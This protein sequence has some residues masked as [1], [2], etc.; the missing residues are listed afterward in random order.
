MDYLLSNAHIVLPNAIMRNG[1]LSIEA[2]RI[3]GIG[4]EADC[5]HGEAT[6][7][8]DLQG[9]F[10][11]PGIVDLHCDMIERM[12]QPRPGVHIP[13]GV[14]LH[15]TDRLLLGCGVT[16]EFHSLSL[17]DDEFGV[18]NDRFVGSFLERLSREEHC[19]ARHFVHARVEVSSV[20]GVQALATMVGHPCLRL[21]SVM[22]HSPGQGQYADERAFRNYIVQT[23][24]RSDAEIDLILERKRIAV[25]YIPAHIAQVLAVAQTHNIPVASHDDDTPAKAHFWA[26]RGLRI[27]EFPTTL[28]AAQAAHEAGLAVGMGAPNVLRGQSSGG[29]LNA[30]TALA[31][32]VV[33]WL[34]ADYYPAALLPAVFLLAEEGLMDLAAAVALISHNPAQAVGMAHELGSITLGHAADLIVV[35]RSPDPIVRQVFVAGRL[36]MR[37]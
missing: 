24:G 5:P 23:T 33:D 15:A 35:E 10:I 20:R 8:D 32:G 4:E 31:A 29:N 3:S 7:H 22:D 36:V 1:W 16:S 25:S 6:H 14:A 26:E 12:V 19:H 27:A 2:G 18:R 13:V 28:S 21:I 11:L 34:C 17:D 30:R 37:I 9:K